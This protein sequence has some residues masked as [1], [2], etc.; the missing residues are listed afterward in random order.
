M[1]APYFPAVL[2]AFSER[3]DQIDGGIKDSLGG[4]FG[5]GGGGGCG[6]NRAEARG[7]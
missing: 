7:P 1:P 3:G 4:M 6:S 5:G 2:E